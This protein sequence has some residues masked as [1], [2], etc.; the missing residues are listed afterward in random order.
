MVATGAS[1]LAIYTTR[2]RDLIPVT[3]FQGPDRVSKA[4]ICA[5]QSMS[6]I[7]LKSN[8]ILLLLYDA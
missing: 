1:S 2:A 8:A 7:Y 6:E 4:H 3:V 5:T